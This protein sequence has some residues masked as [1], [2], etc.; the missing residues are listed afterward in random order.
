M[1]CTYTTL[2]T[3]P[4]NVSVPHASEQRTPSKRLMTVEADAD[5]QRTL[6]FWLNRQP[7]FKWAGGFNRGED[8][9]PALQRRPTEMLLVN[10]LL[11]G[12]SQ[13]LDA[14]KARFPDLPVFTY[15]IYEESDQIFV[16]VSGVEAGYLLRR[17]SA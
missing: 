12:A 11:P 7:G 4:E 1:A 2:L 16:S 14:L 9:L 5:I 6:G 8:V 15:G 17:P 3:L 13:L 10:R